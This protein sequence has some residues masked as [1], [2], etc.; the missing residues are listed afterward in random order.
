MVHSVFFSGDTFTSC[1]FR[2]LTFCLNFFF[3]GVPELKVADV[4]VAVDGERNGE[5]GEVNSGVNG[6]SSPKCSILLGPNKMIE[7]KYIS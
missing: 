3:R 7:N 4:W 1:F 5:A 6:R 2:V